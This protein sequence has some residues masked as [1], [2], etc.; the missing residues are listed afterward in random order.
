VQKTSAKVIDTATN[1][2]EH[3]FIQTPIYDI[4]DTNSTNPIGYKVTD[5]YIQLLSPGQYLIRINSTYTLNNK[6]TISWQYSFVNTVPSVL[7]P[8]GVNAISNVVSTT[9][10]Y[11]RYSGGQVVL[12]PKAD[13][14]RFVLITLDC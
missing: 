7:Y 13:G 3:V 12:T 14:S 6:G 10:N 5:D 8:P 11:N 1:Y 9:C 2:V 4:K